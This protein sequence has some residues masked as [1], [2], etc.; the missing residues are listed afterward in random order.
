MDTGARISSLSFCLRY[1]FLGVD[2]AVRIYRD[3]VDTTFYQERGELRIIA[4]RLAADADFAIFF[5]RRA[6]HLAHDV[7]HGFI[8]L[9]EQL[10][11]LR[12]I[13]IDPEHQLGEIVAADGKTIETLGEF[14]REHNVRRHLAHHVNLQSG[15]PTHEA[16]LSE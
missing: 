1:D 2:E 11:E 13:A 14:L 3:R 5:V 8:S 7:F 6:N 12:G 16:V 9:I 15:A 10:G 4:R